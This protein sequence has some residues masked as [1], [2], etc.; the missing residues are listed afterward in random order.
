M[1][2]KMNDKELKWCWNHKKMIKEPIWVSCI[3]DALINLYTRVCT[4]VFFSKEAWPPYSPSSLQFASLR[5][6]WASYMV[7]GNVDSLP[8]SNHLQRRWTCSQNHAQPLG[9]HPSLLFSGYSSFS[10]THLF[11]SLLF[12]GLILLHFSLLLLVLIHLCFSF[13]SHHSLLHFLLGT[14]P[15][16]D[17]GVGYW[18]EHDYHIIGAFDR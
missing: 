17:T 14:H 15:C 7:L 18:I 1:E 12:S 5:A 11:V 9:T 4:H 10:F 8:L 3:G 6:P 16:R 13:G 2:N